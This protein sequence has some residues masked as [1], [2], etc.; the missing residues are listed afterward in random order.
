MT[1]RQQ[2][3][4]ILDLLRHSPSARL[5]VEAASTA[6]RDDATTVT[7]AEPVAPTA[8]MCAHGRRDPALCPH[9]LGLSQS[10]QPQSREVVIV[11]VPERVA[12]YYSNQPVCGGRNRRPRDERGRLV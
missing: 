10:D 2:R 7:I 3:D 8:V 5:V 1:E 9:C 11:D 4:A 6:R 12:G